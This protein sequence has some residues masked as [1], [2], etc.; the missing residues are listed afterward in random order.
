MKPTSPEEVLR[1]LEL[2][3]VRLAERKCTYLAGVLL[4]YYDGEFAAETAAA[5]RAA[6][7]KYFELGRT[8]TGGRGTASGSAGAS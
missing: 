6:A 4:Q 7:Q 8:P 2:M 3:A 5:R 1:E